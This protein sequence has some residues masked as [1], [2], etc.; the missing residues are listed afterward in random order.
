[1]M[2]SPWGIVGL[3]RGCQRK[4]GGERIKVYYIRGDNIGKSGSYTIVDRS[5][6]RNSLKSA[7]SESLVI[8]R[9]R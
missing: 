9:G 5:F 8:H 1:M 3:R 2:M 4:M 6:V 7:G